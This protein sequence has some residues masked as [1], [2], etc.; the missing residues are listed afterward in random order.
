MLLGSSVIGAHARFSYWY[1]DMW[2]ELTLSNS[3]NRAYKRQ[4]EDCRIFIMEM[5]IEIGPIV[6]QR[7]IYNSTIPQSQNTTTFID[8]NACKMS[9]AQIF[10]YF[11]QASIGY[12]TESLPSIHIYLWGAAILSRCLVLVPTMNFTHWPV[13][14]VSVIVKVSF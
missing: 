14:H 4:P 9:S 7:R 1:F 8:N 10:F 13:E 11:V 5:E 3:R 6:V 2:R 12:K